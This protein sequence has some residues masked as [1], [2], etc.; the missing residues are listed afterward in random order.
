[1]QIFNTTLTPQILFAPRR[2]NL[3]GEHTDY[4]GG[5]VSPA[6]IS[7]GTYAVARKRTDQQFNFYSMN[8][9]HT[10]VIPCS[11]SDLSFNQEHDWANY[12]KG[13]I[14]HIQPSVHDITS[15]SDTVFYRDTLNVTA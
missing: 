15:G 7:F 1:M 5:H 9:A 3:I 13:M 11:L 4:T 2:I 12:P 8:F 14:Q 6:S 10:G